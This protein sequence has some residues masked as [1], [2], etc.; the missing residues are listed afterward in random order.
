MQNFS[1]FGGGTLP[2]TSIRALALD[3]AGAQPI[4]LRYPHG[5]LPGVPVIVFAQF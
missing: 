4:D 2:Q 5:Q 3:T 1:A